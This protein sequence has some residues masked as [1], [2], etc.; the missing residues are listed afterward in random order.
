M[1][2]ARDQEPFAREIEYKKQSW[3]G[4]DAMRGSTVDAPQ[5]YSDVEGHRITLQTW[6]RSS[7]HPHN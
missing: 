1:T 3:A 5:L 6:L 4:C 2:E 7:F